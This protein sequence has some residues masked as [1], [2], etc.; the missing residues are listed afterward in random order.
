MFRRFLLL[1]L[2]TISFQSYGAPYQPEILHFDTKNGLPS[3][4]VYCC[5]QDHNGYMWFGTDNGVVKYNGY[6]F[7]VFNTSNGLPLNS[8][9]KLYEDKLGRIFVFTRA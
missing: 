9:W 1:I 2:I 6:T 8:V 3:N 5:L 7:K 4:N